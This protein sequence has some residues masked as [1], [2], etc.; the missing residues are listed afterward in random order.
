MN[1]E[2]ASSWLHRCLAL[3]FQSFFLVSVG[4]RKISSSQK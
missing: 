3:N 4:K 1:R 2:L